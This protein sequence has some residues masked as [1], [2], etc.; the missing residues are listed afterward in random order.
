[1]NVAPDIAAP[2]ALAVVTGA[3]LA[4]SAVLPVAVRP[5]L[6]RFGVVD[7]PNERSSHERPVLRGLGL[8]VLFAM[9]LGYALAHEMLPRTAGEA[10]AL[11]IVGA[12]SVSSALLGLAEDTRGLSVRARS[13]IQLGIALG[14]GA[15][16]VWLAAAPWWLVIYAV[17][18]LS[19]YINV[20]NF[21]DGLNGISGFHGVIAGVTF[22]LCGLL[23]GLP[24]LAGA[25]AV[26]AAGFLGFLPWN[27]FGRGAFLGD[28]GS[29]LLGGATAATSFA[30][31]VAGVPILATI[32][33]MIL[34]FGDVGVTLVKRMRAGHAWDEPHKEHVYQRV[35]QL[36]R[37]HLSASAIAAGLSSVACGLG[38]VSFFVPPVWWLVLL[39]AGLAVLAL[40]LSLPRLL[41]R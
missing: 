38:L 15:G 10:A 32:A 29:Y 1:M 23:Q 16:L 4:A 11:A 21:M 31:L 13:L 22:A 9:V 33:P 28:V 19:S 12:A 37:S 34:P 27:L 36:G 6:R 35:Q 41:A 14:T 20:A 26:L 7:V 17:F 24:W 18:F 3:T 5:L 40:Y 8:A 2:M 25:G 39:L 30:A